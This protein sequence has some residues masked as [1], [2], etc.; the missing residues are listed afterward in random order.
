MTTPAMSYYEA[1]I[2]ANGSYRR[3]YRKHRWRSFYSA[4]RITAFSWHH[5]DE[6]FQYRDGHLTVKMAPVHPGW[7]VP[8]EYRTPVRLSLDGQQTAA[9]RSA[10]RGLPFSKLRTDPCALVNLM[11]QGMLCEDFCC[12]FRFG[13]SF[14]FASQSAREELEPLRKVLQ[15]I[16]SDSA[17]YR[18]IREMEKWLFTEERWNRLQG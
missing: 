2:R 6:E 17:D 4:G 11:E 16:C 15:Q 7:Q 13:G 1:Q 8:E 14:R 10:V 3:E 9:V 5:K 18:R 12:R